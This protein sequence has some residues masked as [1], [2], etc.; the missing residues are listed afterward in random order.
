[1][2]AACVISNIREFN[3]LSCR[4]LKYFNNNKLLEGCG[5]VNIKCSTFSTLSV[6]HIFCSLIMVGIVVSDTDLNFR[7]IANGY[8]VYRF[9]NTVLFSIMGMQQLQMTG[10]V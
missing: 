3:L 6:E 8:D 7:K 10:Y 9:Y 1:M 5:G 4:L 2:L